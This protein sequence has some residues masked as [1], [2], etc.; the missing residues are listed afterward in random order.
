MKKR[1]AMI[2]LAL[3]FA[4]ACAQS[5]DPTGVPIVEDA[6]IHRTAHIRAVGDVMAHQH[7]LD[8]ALRADGS[9]D[10]SEQMDWVKP[11]L[12]AA[13]YTIANLETVIMP[14]RAY[15]GY[16]TFNTPPEL[17]DTL[18]DAGVDFLTLA[19][20]H[21]LDGGFDGLVSTVDA[22]EA[23]GFDH[24]G[25]Y[26]TPEEAGIPTI[27]EINGIRV[28]FLCYTETANANEKSNRR[29]REY[30]LSLTR[31]HNCEREIEALRA[32]GVDFVI[33]LMHWGTE[34][35]REPGSTEREMAK[36]LAAA[37]A[38]MIIGS[39]PHVVQGIETITVG[40]NESSRTAVV[41]WSLGNFL[42]NMYLQYTYSGIILDFTLEKIGSGPCMVR[43]VGYVPVFVWNRE[44]CIRLLCPGRYTARLMGMRPEEYEKMRA[45]EAE[46][47]D[48]IGEAYPRLAE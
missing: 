8:L 48:L 45:A 23:A 18:R 41:A 25:A 35:K 4:S 34:Y 26:R 42:S 28:G 22:V 6:L 29:A 31:Y 33:C 17:L 19:N 5:D 20:N 13:D 36:K 37:G 30:G 27:I 44:K 10:F 9:Y 14:N 1:I 21:M 32:E 43:D 24:A 7:Q 39:H 46:I 2:L 47:V 38:D 12:R 15:T 40:E 16:P 3:L 11:S